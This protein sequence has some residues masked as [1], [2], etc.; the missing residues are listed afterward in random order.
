MAS[1]LL[2]KTVYT[3]YIIINII[4]YQYWRENQKMNKPDVRFFKY[5]SAIVK[6]KYVV[7]AQ[8]YIFVNK[9]KV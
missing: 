6:V 4:I 1:F 7:F 3:I 8:E 9:N 2:W 5:F